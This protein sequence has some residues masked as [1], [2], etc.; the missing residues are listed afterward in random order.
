MI[1]FGFLLSVGCIIVFWLLSRSNRAGILSKTA[2]NPYL[3]LILYTVLVQADFLNLYSTGF[4]VLAQW[5]I[6]PRDE[7]VAEAL[8]KHNAVLL[9]LALGCVLGGMLGEKAKLPAPRSTNGWINSIFLVAV[10]GFLLI[11]V[12]GQIIEGRSALMIGAESHSGAD[13]PVMFLFSM[14]LLPALIYFLVQRNLIAATAVCFLLAFLLVGTGSR[15]RILY[16]LLPY[17]FYLAYYQR[18][19][20]PKHWF[21]VMAGVAILLSVAAVNYRIL[22]KREG[23]Q[24]VGWSEVLGISE[25][26]NSNDLPFAEAGILLLSR[27]ADLSPF[28]FEGFVGAVLAPIPR[29]MVPFK[30]ETGSVQFTIAYDASNYY[31]RER[32]LVIGSITE[33]ISD[34][35]VILAAAFSFIIGTSWSYLVMKFGRSRDSDAFAVSVVLYI[36]MYAFLRNDIQGVGQIVATFLF[37]RFAF[38][39]KASDRKPNVRRFP[40]PSS[41]RI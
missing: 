38:S 37:V 19:R 6:A 21:G 4:G 8:V 24:N 2:L 32:G 14:L 23:I 11:P 17:L 36:A 33:L 25:I 5:R 12:A 20:F 34:Y 29:V 31:R 30:P 39:R 40:L 16:V 3:F 27:D 9:T 35:F 1:Y 41:V 7:V 10:A 18:I 13:N 22:I 15:T 26:A 28:P